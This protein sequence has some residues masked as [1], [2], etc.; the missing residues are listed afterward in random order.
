MRAAILSLL[1][2]A[3]LTTAQW[4]AYGALVIE[5]YTNCSS[6]PYKNTT[7]TPEDPF[8]YRNDTL[9]AQ[10]SS[11][12]QVE[13][14]FTYFCFAY[15]PDGTW[16]SDDWFGIGKPLHLSKHNVPVQSITCRVE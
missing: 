13:P 1:G 5:R 7:V 14:G 6:A 10:V 8:D 2:L 9:L 4:E 12:Y 11:L 3:A 16:Y 15:K